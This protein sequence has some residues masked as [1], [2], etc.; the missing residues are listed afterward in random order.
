[1]LYMGLALSGVAWLDGDI[2]SGSG[3]DS[4]GICPASSYYAERGELVAPT[5][6]AIAAAIKTTDKLPDTSISKRQGWEQERETMH[7]PVCCGR[8]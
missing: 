2:G 6:A 3:G 1:M 8:C 4:R 5:G 7:I